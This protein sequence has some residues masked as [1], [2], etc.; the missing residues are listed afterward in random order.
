M[1]ISTEL[2]LR[3]TSEGAAPGADVRRD[4]KLVWLRKGCLALAD[5]GLLSGS[6]FLL[7]VLLARWLTRDAYGAYALGFSI[8]I[9]LSGFHNAFFLEPMSVFGPESYASRIGGY[10]RKLAGF[11]FVFAILLS[12][13]VVA[14]A[15]TVPFFMNDR[16]LTSALWGVCIAVPLVLFYW[17]VRRAAY[18]KFAPGLAVVGSATYCVAMLILALTLK[19]WLSPFTGFL[20]QSLAAIPAV[21]VLFACLRSGTDQHSSPSNADVLHQHWRYG[22]WVLGSTVV[23]WVSGY[24]YYVIVG[25]LLPMPDVAALRAL[26]NLTEPCYRAMAAIV[27]LV[28]PWASG[29]YVEE[30]VR[31][32]RRRTRQLNLLFGGTALFYFGALC[33]FGKKVM[34]FLYAGRYNESSHLLILATAPLVFIAASLGS[35]I[36][37]QVMQAPSEVFLAYGVSGVLTFVLGIPFTHFGGLVGGLLSILISAASVWAVLTYRCQKRLQKAESTPPRAPKDSRMM[38]ALP[39]SVNSRRRRTNQRGMQAHGPQNGEVI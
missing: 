38:W 26:R 19:R 37:V 6:N 32:L 18:L 8:F 12:I 36:A 39:D 16:D 21:L 1:Q 14:G 35:E 3:K 15:I 20:I 29:R 27:L 9:L 30:G 28:L 11:H 13:L 31:G 23:N 22:R 25:A 33:L 2:E 10:V 4:R 7:S 5:Q 17:L 34:S 24:G